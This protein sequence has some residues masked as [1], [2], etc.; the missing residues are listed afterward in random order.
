MPQDDPE[1]D[2]A[3]IVTYD[4]LVLVLDRWLL[5]GGIEP[6]LAPAAAPDTGDRGTLRT[7]DL[8]ELEPTIRPEHYPSRGT[9]D[10]GEGTDATPLR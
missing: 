1:A 7:D 3:I 10:Q 9:G 4:R 6:A 2:D 5:H 8:P